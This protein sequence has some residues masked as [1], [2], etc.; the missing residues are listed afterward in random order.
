MLRLLYAIQLLAL[1]AYANCARAQDVTTWHNNNARTGVQPAETVLTPAN[2][3]SANFGKKFS[4]PVLGDI[5]AQPLYLRQ[6]PMAGGQLHNVLL[7]ATAQDYVYAFDA[8]GKNP[9]Q[10]YLWRRLLVGAGETWMTHLDETNEFDIF[11]SI[12]TGVCQASVRKFNE[13][14]SGLEGTTDGTRVFSPR[15]RTI[16]LSF[17]GSF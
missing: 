10:G 3:N 11:P 15:P 2:V 9:A 16:G 6:Y 1:L 17:T 5:Y 14:A 13:L 4:L 12:G 8:D 7:V